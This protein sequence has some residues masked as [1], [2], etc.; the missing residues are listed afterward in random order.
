MTGAID[1]GQDGL[2]SR[3]AGSDASDLALVAG[4]VLLANLLLLALPPEAIAIRTLLGIPLVLFLPGYS[5]LAA[6]F[7]RRGTAGA[8]DGI[9]SVSDADRSSLVW[10]QVR[11]VQSSRIDL[12]TR[13]ALSFGL[14]LTL[15]PILVV[16]MSVVGIG[17]SLVSI[18]TVLTLVSLGGVALGA[19]RRRRVPASERFSPRLQ[20]LVPW[21]PSGRFHAQTTVE[22]ALNVGLVV[23]VLLATTAL[24]LGLTVPNTD[25]RYTEV[26]LLTGNE[27]AERLGDYPRNL[28]VGETSELVLAV[29]NHEQRTQNY[30]VVVQ[31]QRVSTDGNTTDVHERQT[32]TRFG[33]RVESGSEWRAP[34]EFTPQL[35]GEDLRLTYLV[36]RGEPP[37]G[38]TTDSAYRH[39]HVWTNVSE[40]PRP[41]G[42]SR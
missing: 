38:P 4:Y 42:A 15:V 11:S 9:V 30:S 19:R 25:S 10:R 37:E 39:L 31:L 17:T 32:V 34:H 29:K 7:P 28:T 2:L 23:A 22:V 27:S 16:A 35:A 41:A 14:S 36:Y 8:V 3:L 40:R 20:G 13:L 33:E 21:S 1:R 18:L 26:S 12:P 5:L 24:G 6:L